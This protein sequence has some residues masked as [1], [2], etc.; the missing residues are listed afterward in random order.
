[1]R[2]HFSDKG[3]I[4]RIGGEEFAIALPGVTLDEVDRR[5]HA[6]RGALSQTRDDDVPVVVTISFGVVSPAPHESLGAARS[7]ADQAL[8][9]AKRAGRDR[10][11]YADD[12]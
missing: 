11:V 7:R 9:E 5:L 4:G 1:M 8:Y 3:I 12:A 2:E 6:L 10:I